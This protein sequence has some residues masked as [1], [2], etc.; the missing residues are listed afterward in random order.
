MQPPSTKEL[1]KYSKGSGSVLC[2]MYH[3]G[4]RHVA[5]KPREANPRRD[6]SYL[7]SPAV[8]HFRSPKS[9]GIKQHLLPDQGWGHKYLLQQRRFWKTFC[10]GD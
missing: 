5:R 8:R 9:K 3:H 7:R 2:L 10:G 1:S 4:N 6:S